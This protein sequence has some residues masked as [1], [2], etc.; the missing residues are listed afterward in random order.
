M[1]SVMKPRPSATTAVIAR[2]MKS[3]NQG[4]VANCVVSHAVV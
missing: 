3:V 2:P 1:R 4:E